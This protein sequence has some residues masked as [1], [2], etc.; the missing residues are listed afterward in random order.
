MKR[1]LVLV[2]AATFVLASFAPM[3]ISQSQTNWLSVQ[4]V[5][6][7]TGNASLQNS[8]PLLTGHDY[9]VTMQISVPFSQGSSQFALKLN[10][11]LLASGA[12]YWYVKT[13]SYAGYDSSTFSPGSSQ[14]SFT[15][16]QGTV[17]VSVIFGVPLSLTLETAGNLTRH[18]AVMN[19]DYVV[20][21][22]TGGSQ[23]GVLAATVED[24]TIQTYLTTYQQKSTL[25]SSGQIDP[26]YTT[27]VNGI[28][29]QAQAL[30]ALGL[31]DQGTSVLNI[32][33]P[34]SFPTPPSNTTSTA[35]LAGVVVAAVIIVVLLV[36][37]IRGRGKQG[38][39][40][41][42]VTEVQKEL[43]ILEV[44]AAKYDKALAD[45]LQALRNKLSETD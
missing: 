8:Q 23:V 9:N 44:T 36:V 20:A 37:M 28:L 29:A 14:V 1:I 2:L 10:Q 19:F 42:V 32:I 22:V 5:F 38:F 41:G 35:L 17:V 45:R 31:P 13:P 4:S 30:Y 16:V 26:S 43:A 25:I 7:I 40:T 27:V 24:Q 21:T 11:T 34:S 3:T 18:L 39:A 12:Q 6:D 33:T 15:Q